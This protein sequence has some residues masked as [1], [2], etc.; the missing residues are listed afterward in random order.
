MKRS[1]IDR[2]FTDYKKA[3]E[4]IESVQYFQQVESAVKYCNALVAKHWIENGLVGVEKPL[5]RLYIKIFKNWGEKKRIIAMMSEI[6]T[7]FDRRV[8]SLSDLSDIP[9]MLGYGDKTSKSIDRILADITKT[10][11]DRENECK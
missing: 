8:S 2:L 10:K 9:T 3:V 5:R 6:S 7:D 4:V 1:N 11:K